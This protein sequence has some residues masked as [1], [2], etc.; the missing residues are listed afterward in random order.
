MRCPSMLQGNMWEWG[1]DR[2]FSDNEDMIMPVMILGI[3]II[4][5]TMIT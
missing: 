1:A 3:M 5:V 4:R 2:S